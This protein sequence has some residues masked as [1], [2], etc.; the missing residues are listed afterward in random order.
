MKQYRT[1]SVT[2]KSVIYRTEELINSRY[3]KGTQA[4]IRYSED[5]KRAL[6]VYHCFEEPTRLVI[7][8]KGEW[9]IQKKRSILQ[10]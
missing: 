1:L 9:I 2:V 5:N 4:V 8:L 10:T 3:P 6:L 7:P